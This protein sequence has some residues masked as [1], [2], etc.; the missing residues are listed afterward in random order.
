[1][2]LFELLN[3][4]T[5]KQFLYEYELTEKG[6]KKN[7]LQ[8]MRFIYSVKNLQSSNAIYLYEIVIRD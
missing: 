5:L 6:I 8:G 3:E 1:M 7:Y 4:V 2:F